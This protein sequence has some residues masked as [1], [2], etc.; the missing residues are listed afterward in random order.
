MSD[1]VSKDIFSGFRSPRD[2]LVQS[3]I[4]DSAEERTGLEGYPRLAL[5]FSMDIVNSTMYK[6]MTASWPV[7]IRGLMEEMRKQVHRIPELEA[8]ILWR[9]IGDETVFVLPISLQ[10]EIGDAV[11]SIFEVTQKL[12]VS[13]KNGAFFSLL[14][15]QDITRHEINLLKAQSSLSVKSTAWLAVINKK[16]DSAYDNITFSYSGSKHN[17]RMKEYLGRDIDIGFRLKSFTQDR[18]LMVS[19]ELAHFLLQEGKGPNLFILGYLRLKGVWNQALYPAIWY[20]DSEIEARCREDEEEVSF[21]RSFRYDEAENNPLAKEYLSRKAV[22][23]YT[24]GGKKSAGNE[25]ET[26]LLNDEMYSTGKAVPKIISD[27][28]LQTKIK[29]MESLLNDKI[30]LLPVPYSEDLV[31]HCAVICCN[32]TERK[33]MILRRGDAHTTNPGKWEFGCAHATSDRSIENAVIDHYKSI[34]GVE[35]ELI[36]DTGRAEKQPVPIAIYE[37][38]KKNSID[39]GII[40]LAKLKDEQVFRPN[41][42]HTE[43][44][45]ITE[46]EA[47]NIDDADAV[48]DFHQTI[49]AVFSRFDEF[50]GE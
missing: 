34:Y 45:W 48:N 8:C 7:I 36:K 43:R 33:V 28:N 14:E 26:F 3:E 22:V 49:K 4:N 40:L 25:T 38:E 27:R 37:L 31:L 24:G 5:F 39:K 47:K 13:L 15:E 30:Q 29:Y 44:K 1:Q 16:Y 20:Y 19:L 9:V 41:E 2:V 17:Y 35:I 42:G 23:I 11:D 50:F 32:V 46:E 10:K 21:E 6:E 12:S 18:R